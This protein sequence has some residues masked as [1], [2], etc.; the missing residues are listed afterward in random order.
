MVPGETLVQ[1]SLSQKQSALRSASTEYCERAVDAGWVKSSGGLAGLANTL[2]NG[3]T[4]DQ[5]NADTYSARI[6]ANNEAPALVLARIVSDTQAA[7]AGLGDVSREANALLEDTAASTATRADV[8]SYERALVRAQM[9]YRS[10]QS[11]LGDVSARDDMDIDTAPVD[12]ELQAFEGVI[13][14][15]RETADRLADKYAAVNT[16]K[17]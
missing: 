4:S 8:M 5:A 14:N 12:K 16:A 10:F 6:G 11:A 9:A 7:R 2:I 15:A 17:S 1:A 13:D 3:I